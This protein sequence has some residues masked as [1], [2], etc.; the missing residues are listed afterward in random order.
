MQDSMDKNAVASS[1]C[2]KVA[3]F[4]IFW[5]KQHQVGKFKN[6]KDCKQCP[7]QVKDELLNYMKERKTL[8]NDFPSLPH[9]FLMEI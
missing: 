3:N 8:R 1:Y 4:G 6:A 5:G 9:L 2:G 7:E